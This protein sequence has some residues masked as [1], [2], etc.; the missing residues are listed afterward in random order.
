MGCR[1]HL[2]TKKKMKTSI[3][4]I[5]D[6]WPPRVIRTKSGEIDEELCGSLTDSVMITLLYDL[7]FFIFCFAQSI[8]LQLN[9]FSF[10]FSHIPSSSHPAPLTYIF[11]IHLYP[12]HRRQEKTFI[13]LSSMH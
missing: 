7:I 3:R 2:L 13:F 11:T 10:T 4:G 5:C 9:F 8:F 6:L 1:F 12:R